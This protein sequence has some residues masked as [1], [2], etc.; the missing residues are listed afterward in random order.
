MNQCVLGEHILSELAKQHKHTFMHFV[1]EFSVC[2]H[3]G[4]LV[5]LHREVRTDECVPSEFR[6]SLSFVR[7]PVHVCPCSLCVRP[8]VYVRVRVSLSLSLSHSVYVGCIIGRSR[9]DSAR[10]VHQAVT[11][12]DREE[13]RVAVRR[14]F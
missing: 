8:D 10:G 1:R 6:V 2:A 9:P 5:W 11:R 4:P 12:R 13:S 7:V 3:V 14:P